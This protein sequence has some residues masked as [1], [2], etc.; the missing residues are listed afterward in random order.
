MYNKNEEEKE[1]VG[2]K[3]RDYLQPAALFVSESI[4]YFTSPWVREMVLT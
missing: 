1:E 2:E 4:N 3:C